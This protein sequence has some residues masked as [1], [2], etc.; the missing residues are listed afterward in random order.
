[1]K[2]ITDKLQ[3]S[4]DIYSFVIRRKSPNEDRIKM[5]KNIQA[6][7]GRSPIGIKKK[8]FTFRIG[9]RQKI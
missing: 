2:P 9:D 8:R 1:M 5:S 3:N 6:V 7:F 4:T